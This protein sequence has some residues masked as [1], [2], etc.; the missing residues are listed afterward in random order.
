MA[1][2]YWTSSVFWLDHYKFEG[3]I[4]EKRRSWL[5]AWLRDLVALKR[6]WMRSFIEGLGRMGFSAQV[7][8]WLK[9][10]LAPLYA[11]SS[12][13]PPGAVLRLP[14]LI[15][16]TLQFIVDELAA[17]SHVTSCEKPVFNDAEL[18]RTDAKCEGNRV[19]LGGWE[20]KP[21]MEP[22]RSRWFILELSPAETP[23]L[24][25]EIRGKVESSWASTS[26][27]VLGS[28]V[29][30]QFFGKPS[31]NVVSSRRTIVRICGGTDNQAAEFLSVKG[32][33]A[34]LPLTLVMMQL[35]SA[36]RE[37]QLELRLKWRPREL[38]TEAD[39]LTHLDIA[40]FNEDLRVKVETRRFKLDTKSVWR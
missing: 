40:L 20:V 3:G 34:K 15:E 22:S 36:L 35:A 13:T 19:V 7:L 33:S 37:M 6:V 4:S 17:G 25:K 39:A 11:W 28:W 32:G 1:A 26:A 24:F 38:N 21:G 2:W 10:F 30:L 27:E 9:P 23:Y 14:A 8:A 18:F 29:G 31:S 12:A 5:L 16:V